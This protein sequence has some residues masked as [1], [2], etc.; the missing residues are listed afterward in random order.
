MM[1]TARPRRHEA[2]LPDVLL[3]GENLNNDPARD[4]ELADRPEINGQ[5]HADRQVGGIFPR[6]PKRRMSE[7]A[8][9]LTDDQKELS[10]PRR[11][12]PVT[13]TCSPYRG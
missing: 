7:R 12:R 6:H 13:T 4:A 8:V 10:L 1:L 11:L 9:R 3:P 5:A 2:L